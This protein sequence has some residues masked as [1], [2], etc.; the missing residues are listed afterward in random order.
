MLPPVLYS[1]YKQYKA[2]TNYVA[3]WLAQTARSCGYHDPRAP[4]TATSSHSR[5][6][7]KKGKRRKPKTSTDPE[8]KPHVL[9]CDYPA[10]AQQIVQYN[11][12]VVIPISFIN[13]VKR[14]IKARTKTG[15][16]YNGAEIPDEDDTH[17]FFIH[18]LQ[19]VLEI[20]KPRF[21]TQTPAQNTASSREDHSL[22]NTF[23]ALKV[24]RSRNPQTVA[25]SKQPSKETTKTA[26]TRDISKK[27]AEFEAEPMDDVLKDHFVVS[28][29]M[30]DVRRIM[31]YVQNVWQMYADGKIE[32]I[33]A[34]IPANTA[35]DIVSR[36][37][38]DFENESP[39]MKE[40]VKALTWEYIA[41]CNAA[42]LM[43]SDTQ[44]IGDAGGDTME[45]ASDEVAQMTMFAMW[46]RLVVLRRNFRRDATPEVSAEGSSSIDATISRSEKSASEL[47]K[48][49]SI[50]WAGI[51]PLLHYAVLSAWEKGTLMKDEFVRRLLLCLEGEQITLTLVFAA[52]AFLEALHLVGNKAQDA[53]WEL[54]QR[55]MWVK[56][57]AEK[58]LSFDHRGDA[59]IP[60]SETVLKGIIS[61]IDNFILADPIHTVA[62]SRL[63]KVGREAPAKFAFLRKHPLL[64]GLLSFNI[65]SGAERGQLSIINGYGSVIN[66]AHLINALQQ[67]QLCQTP[68]KNMDLALGTQSRD[69]IFCSS[70][71]TNFQQYSSRL[72]LALGLSPTVYAR[73][74]RDRGPSSATGKL[75]LFESPSPV[76]QTFLDWFQG[77]NGVGLGQL[78]VLINRLF[79]STACNEEPT[80]DADTVAMGIAPKDVRK[81]SLK[82]SRDGSTAMLKPEELLLAVAYAMGKE[83]EVLTFDWLHLHRQC[84]EL[85]L[86]LDEKLGDPLTASLGHDWKEKQNL[87]SR[88]VAFLLIDTAGQAKALERVQGNRKNG[89]KQL[90]DKFEIAGE[91][92]EQFLQ[93][94]AAREG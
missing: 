82:T 17:L 25:G 29:L 78:E 34:S 20:L 2:D 1:T 67:E 87:V 22:A 73:N 30:D 89:R 55:G 39:H 81:S 26:A 85:L 45:F 31:E 74:R 15:D 65:L 11:P 40:G 23:S 21:P 52:Q 4:S 35:V 56:D 33:A 19:S 59:P 47:I 88:L 61:N 58:T 90:D 18:T 38:E 79:E 69:H 27:P 10:L 77:R 53:F 62:K 28:C 12:P 49:A 75:R 32:L 48:D 51:L 68:W 57:S 71:P 24:E 37:E 13:T 3:D 43:D 36:L 66:C 86:R 44:V 72:N 94:I 5:K 70:R 46:K 8:T 60:G 14:T 93:E 50:A 6:K 7:G 92:T 9:V 84:W 41:K 83:V 16:H 91:I 80:N 63:R 64:C 42:G 76:S 54:Q